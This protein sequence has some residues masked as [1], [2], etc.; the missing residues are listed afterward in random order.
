MRSYGTVAVVGLS[1]NPMRPSHTVA[2]YLM[3]VGYKIIPV[4]PNTT[5]VFGKRSYADLESVPE[6]VEVV[7]IFRRSEMVA[8]VVESAIEIGAKAIWMQESVID[9][10]A[11][12]KAESAGLRV[13]MDKCMLKEHMKL[14]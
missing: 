1:P 6:R 2:K 7:D 13:V 10:Q 9:E 8:P 5:E 14:R 12:E 11:K 3:S 4:N